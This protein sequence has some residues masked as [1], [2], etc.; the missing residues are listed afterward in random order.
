[1]LKIGAS[2]G[3]KGYRY[4]LTAVCFVILD[5]E[6]LHHITVEL[7]TRVAQFYG[8]SASTVEKGIATLIR[9]INWT[10][11]TIELLSMDSKKTLLTPTSAKLIAQI[12]RVV[13]LELRPVRN[14]NA[15]LQKSRSR[16]MRFLLR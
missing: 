7:Y 12:S 11:E 16:A 15:E 10:N 8:T 9:N 3:Y 1:M 5:A 13:T 2:P 4:L 14:E 6:L